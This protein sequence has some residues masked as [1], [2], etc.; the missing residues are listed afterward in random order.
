MSMKIIGAEGL[1]PQTIRDEVARGA[2]FV[3]YHYCVSIVV[4]TFKRP[5]NIYF[6]GSSLFSVE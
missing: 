3:I 5:S 1:D 6:I 2:R 4:M